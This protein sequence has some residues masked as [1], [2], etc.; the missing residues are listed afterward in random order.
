MQ[1][2]LFFLP[3]VAGVF[4]ATQAGVNSQLRNQTGSAIV[5]AF[6]SFLTGTIALAALMLIAREPFPSWQIL[7]EATWSSYLGGVL[8]VG[9]VMIIIY[10]AQKLGAA[11]LFALI[12]AAQLVSALIYDH[13]G[14]LGFKQSQ[15]TPIR[16]AGVLLL[17][18][19]AYLVNR[20]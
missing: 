17:I 13:F 2:I 5:A 19:G 14:L 20:K 8:G 1:T 9:F 3:L 4:I 6:I 10:A 15:V 18:A 7:R 11:N 12:V 16:I